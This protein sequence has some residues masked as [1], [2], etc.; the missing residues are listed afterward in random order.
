MN[1]NNAILEKNNE[2]IETIGKDYS[3]EISAH[4]KILQNSNNIF[5]K[6]KNILIIFL[7]FTLKSLNNIL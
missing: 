6:F 4:S 5:I 1:K 7:I 2:I 3:N